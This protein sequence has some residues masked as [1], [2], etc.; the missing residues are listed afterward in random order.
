MD[1]HAIKKDEVKNSIVDLGDNIKIGGE[2]FTII[3]GPCAVESE[4]QIEIVA[5]RLSNLGVKILRGG[6]YKP[7][8]SPYAFQGLG[9]R[10]LKILKNVGKKYKMKVI[11]EIMDARHIEDSYDLVDIFQIG[12]RNM[13]NY[14]LLK[15]IGKLKKPVLLKRGISATMEEWLMAAEYIASEGNDNIILCERGIRT[16]EKYT[17]NTLDLVAVPIVK[18]LTRLPII[19]DPSHGT[20]R[21]ELIKPVTRAALAIGANGVMIEVHP[22][23]NEALSDGEQSLNLEEIEEV[24]S[25]IELIKRVL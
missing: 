23:P 11:S 20:G 9:L 1:I 4:E 19:V 6:A 16:F 21:K 10:G 5:N 8:T 13:Q 12:S 18:E 25:D 15:E 24:I 22:K 14:T 17:R 7:R 2:E 3:A